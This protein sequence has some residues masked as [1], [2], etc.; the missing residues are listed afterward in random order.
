[1][2]SAL[3]LTHSTADPAADRA[4]TTAGNTRHGRGA[5]GTGNRTITPNVAYV[6]YVRSTGGAMP[7][8]ALL[9]LLFRSLLKIL[10]RPQKVT[11]SQHT[12]TKEKKRKLSRHTGHG[13][14]FR[15]NSTANL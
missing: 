9:G 8:H 11:A 13:N 5:A 10:F 4:K 1:L 14:P 12:R 6:K 3:K 15:R 7:T 2:S